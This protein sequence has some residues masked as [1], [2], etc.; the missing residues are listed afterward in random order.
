MSDSDDEQ[1]DVLDS[2]LQQSPDLGIS[3]LFAGFSSGTPL[4]YSVLGDLSGEAEVYVRDGTKVSQEFLE[5]EDAW[6]D[7]ADISDIGAAFDENSE[8]EI[9]QIAISPE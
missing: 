7:P 2:D 6:W 4:S 1:L 3:D 8:L 9:A 5:P